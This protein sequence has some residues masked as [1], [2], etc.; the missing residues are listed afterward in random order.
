MGDVRQ[1]VGFIYFMRSSSGPKVLLGFCGAWG[2]NPI[3]ILS[4]HP[5]DG[6]QLPTESIEKV[7]CGPLTYPHVN[8]LLLAS[9]GLPFSTHKYKKGDVLCERG[10]YQPRCDFN[11]IDPTTIDL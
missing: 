6:A 3:L 2:P 7:E 8:H 10:T 1:S 4:F 5:N 11:R 9:R